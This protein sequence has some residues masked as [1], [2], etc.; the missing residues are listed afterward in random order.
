[1]L[2]DELPRLRQRGF[3]RVRLNGEVRSLDETNLIPAGPGTKEIT[4]EIVIDRLVANADQRSRLADSLELAFRE[5]KDRVVVLAQKNAESP[6]H[7][8]ALSQS[9]SCESCGDSFEKLTP[10]HFSF[11]HREGACPTCDGL[12]RKLRFVP[13]LIVADPEKS[14]REGALKP[15]R[16]GGKNLIIKHNALLKQLAEQLPFD[17]DVPWNKL[18]EATRHTILHGAGERLF[19]FKLRRMREPKAMPFAGVIADLEDSFRHT[20]SEGFQARLITFMVAGE[21]PECHGTRLNA[22]RGAVRLR[23]SNLKSEISNPPDPGL[24]FPEFMAMDIALRRGSMSKSSS[25]TPLFLLPTTRPSLTLSS[26][27]CRCNRIISTLPGNAGVASL[28]A[29][30][31]NRKKS[32][33][34]DRGGP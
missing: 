14:V 33:G 16:I 9:L 29:R 25:A 28:Q 27:I 21:C 2:R 7:E 30:W 15:W 17:A 20:G 1:M 5:G 31:F 32:M 24:T 18:P 10:R 23:L 4:V 26:L 3:Q 34:G 12:G 8:L 11:S 13:E 22:R 19:A 6:W